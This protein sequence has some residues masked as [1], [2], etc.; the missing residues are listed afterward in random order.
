MIAAALSRAAE[1]AVPAL[2]DILDVPVSEI[3]GTLGWAAAPARRAAVEANLS[4]IAPGR[5]LAREVFVCQARHYVET[6][7][8]L[9]LAPVTL[10]EMVR[11]DGWGHL[12]A[13]LARGKGVM[14]AS[15]HLGP[16]VLCGQ[17]L[18]A[19]GLDVSVTVE[20]KTGDIGR[21]IDRARGSMGIKTIDIR[22]PMAIGRV[23]RR[24][25]ILGSLADRPVSGVGERVTFFGREA[26]L[27]SA[28]VALALHTGAALL[29]AFA[30]REG[31]Q[32]HAVMGP[33]LDL[34]RTGDR[35][36]DLR[37]GVQRWAAI[38][39][40]WVARAPEQWSVFDRVWD[41]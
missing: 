3:V 25:A 11:L 13:A 34:V 28:H 2:P 19:R 22:S 27:P 23:L 10:I 24:G 15:A 20:A 36:A 40:Q 32:L 21:V 38:L 7:R 26:L 5:R 35:D 17:V 6:F 8:I 30:L 31:G 29:P 9:R 18:A 16:V 14:L 12:Q 33:E 1:R 41:R 39:E 37:D 4:V